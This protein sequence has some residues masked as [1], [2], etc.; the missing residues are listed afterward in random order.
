MNSEGFKWATIGLWILTVFVHTLVVSA[1][2]GI[3]ISSIMTIFLLVALTAQLHSYTKN[4]NFF[5]MI[6]RKISGK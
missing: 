4:Y 5:D 1:S 6:Y 3:N 2:A